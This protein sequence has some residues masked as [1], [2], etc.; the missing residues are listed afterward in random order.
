MNE[1]CC[2]VCGEELVFEE[3]IE[4]AVCDDCYNEMFKDIEF[5]EQ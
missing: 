3:E 1:L 2:E 5:W 4:A